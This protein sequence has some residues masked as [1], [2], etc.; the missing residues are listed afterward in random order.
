MTPNDQ[1]ARPSVL[2]RLQEDHDLTAAHLFAAQES[3]DWLAA[4]DSESALEAALAA[5]VESSQIE[6]ARELFSPLAPED[7]AKIAN[8]IVTDH[9]Q[10]ASEPIP[11]T[12]APRRRWWL[13]S[14]PL[15]AAAAAAVTL[16]VVDQRM[17]AGESS[18]GTVNISAAVRGSQANSREIA[19]G[20]SFYLDCHAI[21]REITV[22]GAHA[23]PIAPLDG[24]TTPRLL[25]GD[26]VAVTTDGATYH[27]RADLPPGTWEVTCD[28]H[29]PASGRL[30][31]L[32]PAASLVVR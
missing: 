29:E 6:T 22:V 23:V 19:A 15:T 17:T 20:A 28:V 3:D 32:A 12:A 13:A 4:S 18:D 14:L 16:L 1:A 5:N 2:E 11:I 21:D 9:L 8:R 25:G 26:R 30:S 31:T 27:L 10:S 7:R 24:D